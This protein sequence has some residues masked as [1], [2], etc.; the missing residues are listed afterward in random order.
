MIDKKAI[1]D[2]ESVHIAF[3]F[4]FTNPTV[5]IGMDNSFI[6]PEKGQLYGSNKDFYSVQDGLIFQTLLLA[7]PFPVRRELYLK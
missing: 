6:T 4:A 7:L 2:K 1:R 3:P 5:R